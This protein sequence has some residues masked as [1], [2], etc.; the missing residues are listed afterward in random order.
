M[1]SS[2]ELDELKVA[3]QTL[4]RRLQQ[5]DALNLLAI[6]QGTAQRMRSN[7]RPLAWGQ[8][9]Q[10]L[11]GAAGALWLAPFWVT[12]RHEP[13]LLVA[14]LTLHLYSL[15]LIAFGAVMQAQIARIDYAGPVLA[16]QRRLLR[17]RRTY[18]RGGLLMGLPWWCLWVPL[19]MVVVK[20]GTG[21]DLFERAPLFVWINLAVGAV[22]LLLTAGCGR[23]L[24][25]PARARLARA[26]DDSA[27]GASIRRAQA[28]IE[29]I[30][31]FEQ[32]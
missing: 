1:D 4:D 15:G 22:G 26:L 10:M 27:A 18:V 31:R 8:A 28:E 16:I 23:W 17:L 11:V 6:R 21:T 3:W 24:Q 14:G 12:H 19:L 30:A 9:I 29:E 7:L 32:D 25:R 2:M 13:P 5:H 20:A